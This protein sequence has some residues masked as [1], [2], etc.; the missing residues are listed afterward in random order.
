[1]DRPP[2]KWIPS[3]RRSEGGAAVGFAAAFSHYT[4][5]IAPKNVFVKKDHRKSQG[6]RGRM[7][8][9][10][11]RRRRRAGPALPAGRE[12]AVWRFDRDSGAGKRDFR[13]FCKSRLTSGEGVPIM[14]SDNRYDNIRAADSIHLRPRPRSTKRTSRHC[15][16]RPGKR[17]QK[18]EWKQWKSR[19]ISRSPRRRPR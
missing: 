16:R 17:K 12:G 1:M 2:V 13:E 14:T 6:K 15:L 19:P 11:D 9:R 8:D 3:G 18:G 7:T 10:V 5:I 4:A